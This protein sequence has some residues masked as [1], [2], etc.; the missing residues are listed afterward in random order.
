MGAYIDE[1][2]IRNG[3]EEKKNKLLIAATRCNTHISP[4][5]DSTL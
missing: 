5:G 3:P 2:D 4:P 1:Y